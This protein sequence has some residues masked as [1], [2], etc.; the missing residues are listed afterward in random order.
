M[1]QTLLNKVAIITGGGRGI[2]ASTAELFASEGAK[3]VV[4]SRTTAELD[5]VVSKIGRDRALG[6]RVDVS[7]EKSVREL[8]EKTISTFGKV[9]ILI[10]NAGV[11]M[12]GEVKALSVETW[13][14]VIEVNLRGT[15]LCAREAMKVMKPGG[16]IVNIASIAGIRGRAKFPGFSAYCAS[17]FG[18][19]G[20]TEVLAEE[21]R[22]SGIR[23]NC[24]APG[25]I[26][27]RML[28]EALPGVVTDAKP[29]D[30]AGVALSLCDE[31]RSKRVTGA[32]V[33]VLTEMHG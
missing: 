12:A 15:F 9:D 16:N 13:N 8:F 22:A 24:I 32:V 5:S 19:V 23:V 29:E 11:F 21:G 17:K 14:K 10:N 2:G 31:G 4:A 27:T 26:D 6:V 20:F 7:D 25:A 33:E 18:V 30:I 28:R 3:V 1:A